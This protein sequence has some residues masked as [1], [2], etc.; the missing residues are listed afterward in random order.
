[1]NRSTSG[2][3][4]LLRIVQHIY[5]TVEEPRCWP[6]VLA[7]IADALHGGVAALLY[8]DLQA[9]HGG[10]NES[11]RLAPDAVDSYQQHFHSRDPWGM[12]T[13]RLGVGKTGAVL[14]GDRLVP[15][16]ELRRT[17]YYADYASRYDLVRLLAGV[18]IADGPVLSVISILRAERAKPFGEKERQQL[19]VLM[20]HLKCVLEIR[21]KLQGLQ[22]LQAAST[23]ALDQLPTGVILVDASHRIVFANAA[24]ERTLTS[25]AGLTV[26]D[27][28]LEAILA[29]ET[30]TLRSLVAAAVRTTTGGDALHP[31]G[32]MNV[33]RPQ[34][35]RPLSV[36]VTPVPIAANHGSS[37]QGAAAVLI[38]NPDE[39]Q[40]PDAAVLRAVFGLTGAECRVVIAMCSGL[41][42]EEAA[43]LLEITKETARSY[44]KHAFAKTG[45]SRQSELVAVVGRLARLRS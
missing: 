41:S 16:P 22:L 4:S 6:A 43:T 29:S 28:R 32:A 13:A 27:G 17:E 24:A 19:S 12:A 39:P 37:G 26:E 11:V 35:G 42:L 9:H 15:L 14:N 36:L 25:G 23:H 20:G 8:H 1:M 2:N 3:T 31:G 33:S 30:T 7:E 10:L 45:T 44:L 18:V 21:R 34:S 5:H 40:A 38:S